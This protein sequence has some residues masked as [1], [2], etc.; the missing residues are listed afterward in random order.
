MSERTSTAVLDGPL[1]DTHG[2]IDTLDS[3][4]VT[5]IGMPENVET[6]KDVEAQRDAEARMSPTERMAK[7]EKEISDDRTMLARMGAKRGTRIRSRTK[8][9]KAEMYEYVHG[10]YNQKVVE[11]G[12][13]KLAESLEDEDLSADDKKKEVLGYLFSEQQKL[14]EETSDKLEGTP[15]GK[16]VKWMNTGGRLKKFMKVAGV[17][18]IA[19]AAGMA[20]GGLAGGLIAAGVAG[21]SRMFR[22]FVAA[23]GKNGRA[24]NDVDTN[25]LNAKAFENDA[26]SLLDAGANALGESFNDEIK[27]RQKKVRRAFGRGALYAG[28]G[29]TIGALVHGATG[30]V[31]HAQT[32]E[33]PIKAGEH[34]MLR[35]VADTTDVKAG[36]HVMLAAHSETVDAFAYNPSE[37]PFYA[38]G[39]LGIHDMG[40]PLNADPNL[41]G[42]RPAGFNDLTQ[43]RW[44]D[45]PEQFASI[46]SAMGID[47]LPDN[48][49]S[50]NGLA[51]HFKV[52]PGDMA[53][54]HEKVMGIINDPNTHISTQ[55]IVNPYASEY[56]VDM[57]NGNM[58]LAWDDYVNHGGTKTVIEFTDGNGVRRVL[59]LRNECGGQRIVELPD[60]PA[61]VYQETP[62][63]YEQA[64][65]EGTGNGTQTFYNPPEEHTPQPP[66]PQPPIPPEVLNPKISALDSNI[67]VLEGIQQTL[68]DITSGALQSPG[69]VTTPGATII[70][71]L[72]QQGS[73]PS[74]EF[75]PGADSSPGSIDI[76][77][78][79]PAAQP[80]SNG[81]DNSNSERVN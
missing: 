3:P 67:R 16:V 35:P 33:T 53:S 29:A 23:E 20:T 61:P 71:S 10:A 24:L 32:A 25:M 46:A 13:L 79:A 30:A 77:S 39:K 65:Y 50:A 40:T 11:L 60:A 51:E 72:G 26:H 5:A 27:G 17:G 19:G 81:A 2:S 12:R 58:D 4:E 62:V 47:N 48:M 73:T 76:H 63:Y 31:A 37:N 22:G 44:M 74:T 14:R 41:D 28:A 78:D 57:G 75:A 45:S 56:G 36:E 66:T 55:N 68:G 69:S 1:K 80:G 52:A 7:L 8:G 64:Q 70:D 49:A 18:L 34:N 43:H 9:E 15:M 6:I 42:G 59:E 38:P 54:M 21:G